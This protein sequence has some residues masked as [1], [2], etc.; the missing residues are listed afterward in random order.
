MRGTWQTTGGDGRGWLA[1]FA[2]VAIVVL[3]AGGGAVAAVSEF[4]L[5]LV[6]AIGGLVLLLLAAGI[7]WLWRMHRRGGFAPIVSYQPQ[8]L[9]APERKAAP[10]VQPPQQVTNNFY[11]YRLDDVARAVAE[12]RAIDERR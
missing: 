4:V 2:V 1:L 3:L 7:W 11:G 8:A 12:Q 9:P 5:V 6:A 10:P